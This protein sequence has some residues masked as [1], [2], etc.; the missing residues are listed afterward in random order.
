[1]NK[2]LRPEDI[3]PG[4]LD[5]TMINGVPVRKGTVGAFLA[6]VEMFESVMSTNIQK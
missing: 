6:N 4:N 3:L 1:M 2:A 5:K